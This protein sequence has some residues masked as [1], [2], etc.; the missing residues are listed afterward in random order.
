MPAAPRRALGGLPP[1]RPRRRGRRMHPQSTR[2]QPTGPSEEAATTRR[3]ARSQR[4]RE[5][6]AARA[7]SLTEQSAA[8]PRRRRR[9][10]QRARRLQPAARELPHYAARRSR[11]CPHARLET[12]AWLRRRYAVSSHAEVV[13]GRHRPTHPPN[14]RRASSESTSVKCGRSPR[15]PAHCPA[16]GADRDW[17]SAEIPHSPRGWN[18]DSSPRWHEA[19]P[20]ARW[21]RRLP[22]P[23]PLRA[24]SHGRQPAPSQI[25]RSWTDRRRT[26]GRADGCRL[27]Q[28]IRSEPRAEATP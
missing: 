8:A 23:T 11:P 17:R 12:I 9:A 10:S 14:R 20:V 5:R 4:L 25:G 13:G 21:Q 19:D 6:Q 1:R 18:A 2:G 7:A 22:P 28:P 27:W 15:G 26:P 3:R 24:R 16:A